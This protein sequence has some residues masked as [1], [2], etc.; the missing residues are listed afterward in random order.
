MEDRI[1]RRPTGLAGLLALVAAG[2]SALALAA[3]AGALPAKFFGVHWSTPA[4]LDGSQMRL[5]AQT[6]A[7]YFRAPI[8]QQT[9]PY[10]W[11]AD[12]RLFASAKARGI[13]ILPTF[14][15]SAYPP[16]DLRAWNDFVRAAVE[17]YDAKYAP[18]AWEV[19]NEPNFG[20]NNPDGNADPARYVALLHDTA[21]V[22]R[23]AGGKVMFAS[24]YWNLKS[25][26]TSTGTNM[27]G[28]AFLTAALQLGA[29]K[30]ADV[31]GLHPYAF[32]DPKGKRYVSRTAGRVVAA[33]NQ[34][35]RAL[36]ADASAR[37]KSIWIT[38]LGWPVAQDY[39]DPAPTTQSD[40]AADALRKRIDV[41]PHVQAQ[42]LTATFDA[43]ARIAAHDDVRSAV[44]YFSH[45]QSGPSPYTWDRYAGLQDRNGCYRPAYRAL[46]AQTGRHLRA[47][48]LSSSVFGV[49]SGTPGSVS[50]RGALTGGTPSGCVPVEVELQR[51]E[52]GSWRAK[53]T[54]RAGLASGTYLVSAHPVAA[55]RWRVRAVYP[56][57]GPLRGSASAYHD[58]EIGRGSGAT[59]ISGPPGGSH[60]GAPPPVPGLTATQAFVTVDQALNGQP[61]WVTV[62]GHVLGGSV[63]LNGVYVNVNF[64]RQQADGSWQTMSSAHPVLVDGAYEV[65]D[66]RVGDGQWRVR[67]VLPQQ[68]TFAESVS[69]YRSFAIGAGYRLVN[70]HSGLC[71]TISQNSVANGAPIIQWP[72]FAGGPGDG[73]VLTRVPIGG[74][75]HQLVFNSSGKCLDVTGASA[76]DGAFLQQWDCLGPG[77]A[78]QLWQTIPIAGQ[79]GWF[80]FAAHH[81]GK[82]ADVLGMSVNQGTR[83]GQ[84]SCTWAGNQQWSIQAVG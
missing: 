70:R 54:V 20:F 21:P 28:S 25:G 13:A 78:N 30:D 27:S 75:L 81:S 33:T 7:R 22:I 74:G 62:H 83:V 61:G 14:A 41:T 12:D 55:G 57:E 29:G 59:P 56:G 79:D 39:G 17:R 9:A 18:P 8:I 76:A 24:L 4:E 46:M 69:D 60:P 10:D 43:I 16:P 44:W 5:V 67:T 48:Q 6:G 45:D 58:F 38:E 35:R 31:F 15:A 1:R 51:L 40:I 50:V 49:T 80:A 52:S 42:L 23:E 37:G 71:L 64:Q 72:C 11:T 2:A 26:A 73:Q 3:P 47:T 34:L 82:C 84:W 19:L 32:L 68:G 65:D 66:W 63:P 36:D 53:G 77:Q